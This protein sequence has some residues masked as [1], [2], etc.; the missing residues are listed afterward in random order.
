MN[1]QSIL[2]V[3]S[4]GE[5]QPGQSRSH[6]PVNLQTQLRGVAKRYWLERIG[7]S[8]HPFLLTGTL[9][10]VASWSLSWI[11]PLGWFPLG[12]LLLGW[13]AAFSIF[14]APC[15]RKVPLEVAAGR[16][17]RRAG[18]ADQFRSALSFLQ[19]GSPG[20]MEKLTVLR[21]EQR[22][23][24][25]SWPSLFPVHP[26]RRIYPLLLVSLLLQ[27]HWM[28]RQPVQERERPG[29]STALTDPLRKELEEHL[30]KDPDLKQLL[31]QA[32]TALSSDQVLEL[33]E[34]MRDRL[35]PGALDEAVLASDLE[36][37]N[38][39]QN[40]E[41]AL[42]AAL[43]AGDLS[44][45][46]ENLREAARNPGAI[47][48][49]LQQFL[50]DLPAHGPMETQ[51]MRELAGDLRAA[52]R[53]LEKQDQAAAAE[54]LEKAS[55]RLDELSREQ[56]ARGDQEAAARAIESLQKQM[57]QQADARVPPGEQSAGTGPPGSGGS[58]AAPSEAPLQ[59]ASGGQMA[60]GTGDSSSDSSSDE[61]ESRDRSS[62][63][64]RFEVELEQAR[65]LVQEPSGR[66]TR[67]LPS[68]Q[69]QAEK[70]SG[71][72]RITASQESEQALPVNMIPLHLRERI[73]QYLIAINHGIPDDS[74]N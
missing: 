65:S 29:L 35:G 49:A 31:K 59:E 53:A 62:L 6:E 23:R 1:Q 33:L 55:D 74:G 5:G 39:Q 72:G 43:A 48:P 15:L 9:V 41:N 3:D 56:Q 51:Q 42:A 30:A 70:P 73:R 7:R 8:L 44:G 22:F 68:I 20:D 16:L 25:L 60:E 57:R 64:A 2:R 17:D 26:A 45:L 46:A 66:L 27:G 28:W 32:E 71:G 21:A 54:Q 47:S 34:E 14:M 61:P 4:R 10:T 11:S 58:L 67:E 37:L 38:S 24:E 69:V 63:E 13:L 52:Q 40:P 12:L 19:R 18:Q 36:A 50:E